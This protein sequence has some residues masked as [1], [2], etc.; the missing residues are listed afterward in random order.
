[1]YRNGFE[2]TVL[3]RGKAV[4]EYVHNGR[5]YIEGRDDSAYKLKIT[6]NSGVDAEV[7]LSVDGLD[8]ID[9]EVASAK[10]TGYVVPAWRSIIVDGWRLNDRESAAFEFGASGEAYAASKDK[11]RNVG[12]IGAAFYSRKQ[13][14]YY[15]SSPSYIPGA[16]HG[17][18]KSYGTTGDSVFSHKTVTRSVVGESTMCS[19]SSVNAPV[20]ET[21]G[22][23]VQS[24]G[25]GT[26]FGEKQESHVNHVQFERSTE[27]PNTVIEVHYNNRRGLE[28]LGIPV[29]QPLSEDTVRRESAR[30]F[31]DLDT[32]CKPPP[33]WKG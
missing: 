10:K 13:R 19:V 4:R 11:P 6:N 31:E 33:G 21:G 18:P 23:D 28:E 30:A 15:P 25:L 32:G 9:G 27:V 17:W 24:V 26:R 2:F 16:M 8:V 22:C 20:G 29:A 14:Y 5:T 12:V 3:V 7:V 1:M